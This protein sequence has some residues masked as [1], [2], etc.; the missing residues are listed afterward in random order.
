VELI[1]F[2]PTNKGMTYPIIQPGEQG[3]CF[4]V[5]ARKHTNLIIV[6]I[7]TSI[8]V[9]MVAVAACLK[10]WEGEQELGWMGGFVWDLS[11]PDR[12]LLGAGKA[13]V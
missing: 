10:L 8:I 12:Q 9:R 5:P 11:A 3:H 6:A 4:P 2:I 7:L 13:K 1:K